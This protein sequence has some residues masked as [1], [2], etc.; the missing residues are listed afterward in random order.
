MEAICGVIYEAIVAMETNKTP[1]GYA[2]LKVQRK[3]IPPG[4]GGGAE[5]PAPISTFREL[6]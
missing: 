5:V 2:K 4:G 1:C 3:L 6:S